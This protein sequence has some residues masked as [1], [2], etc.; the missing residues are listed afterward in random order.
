[1]FGR[2]V[3]LRR[4]GHAREGVEL[5][6]QHLGVAAYSQRPLGGRLRG[7]HCAAVLL[8]LSHP[9]TDKVLEEEEGF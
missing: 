1:M 7:S 8:L 9:L 4:A 3:D 5:R 6:G 2:A